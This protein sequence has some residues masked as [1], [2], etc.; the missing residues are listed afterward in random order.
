M[1]NYPV[2]YTPSQAVF[3]R[4]AHTV[5]YIT[6]IKEDPFKNTLDLT[7]R[8][9]ARG[10]LAPESGIQSL[11]IVSDQLDLLTLRRDV[12]SICMLCRI[13]Y[14]E[15]SVE[16]LKFFPAVEFISRCSS[17]RKHHR[18]HLVGWRSA[19]VHLMRNVPPST[20]K[21]LNGLPSAV[22]LN[23]NLTGDVDTDVPFVPTS[24]ASFHEAA[25]LGN[26][27]F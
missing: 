3:T 23:L 8:T 21:L 26:S 16:L 20:V 13:Y 15:C 5:C 2:A 14:D 25:L 27:L 22:V 4:Q 19:T 7:G 11:P 6:R 9:S 17:D 24:K 12:A 10:D 18:N 1:V